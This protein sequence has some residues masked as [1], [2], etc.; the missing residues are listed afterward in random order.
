MMNKELRLP[1][2]VRVKRDALPTAP[3]GGKSEGSEVIFSGYLEKGIGSSQPVIRARWMNPLQ[4]IAEPQAEG[5]KQFFAG[6][7]FDSRLGSSPCTDTYATVTSGGRRG[8][9]S[10][11]HCW[12]VYP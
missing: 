6:E 3:D 7:R 1:F 9:G 10:K 5:S 12:P 8:S 2:W 4:I 11:A